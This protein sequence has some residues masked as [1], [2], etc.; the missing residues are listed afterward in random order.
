LRS[1]V[2]LRAVE[3]MIHGRR[4]TLMDLARAW[5]GAERI[6]TQLKALDRLL[7]NH[8]LHA[9]HEHIYR[10]MAQWLVRNNQPVIVI[11]WSDLKQDRSWH[12]LR[13]AIPAGGRSLPILDM[14]FPG[15]QQGSPKA[16]KQLL[17]RLPPRSDRWP[18]P[19]PGDRCRLPGTVV[20]GDRSDGLAVAGALTQHNLSQTRRG[21]ERAAVR[22]V[23][24]GHA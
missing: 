3:A 14:V 15:E 18:M 17:Q 9:E 19:V 4:L 5:P 16:E 1:R 2:L 13:A 10:A 7:G 12:L 22:G 20:P 24:Q 11:D 6:R 23:V 21:A 8:H